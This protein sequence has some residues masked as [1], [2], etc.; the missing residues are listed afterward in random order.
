MH[1]SVRHLNRLRVQGQLHRPKGRPRHSGLSRPVCAGR[2]L[3]QVTPHLSCV[4]VH[5]LARWL[6]QQGHCPPVVAGLQPAITRSQQHRADDDFALFHH[7]DQTLRGRLQAL[8]FA[9]LLGIEPVAGVDTHEHP[10]ETLLGRGSHRSPLQQVL[11]QRERGGAAGALRPALLP[12]TAGQIPYVDGVMIASWSRRSMHKGHIT[13]LGRLMAGSQA[14]IAHNAKGQALFVTSQPPDVQGSR[15]LGDSGHKG[16][17]ATGVALCVI[18]RA[19]HAGAIACAFDEHGFGWLC[20][21]DEHESDGRQSFAATGVDRLAD[22]P[23]LARGQW[24][25]PRPDDPRPCVMVEPVAGKPLGSWGTPT[26]QAAV[27]PIAWPRVYR[28]R[29]AMPAHRVKGMMDHGALKTTY[30]RKTRV[31]PDRHQ[32]RARDELEQSLAAAHKRVDPKAPAVNAHQD[33]V[34]ASASKGPGKRLAQRRHALARGDKA[35]QEAQN[36]PTKLREHAAAL[37]PPRQRA[38]RDVR[39]QTMMTFRTLVLANALMAFMSVLVGPLDLQGRLDCLLTILCER[40]GARMETDCHVVYWV[41][42]VGLSASSQRLLTAM[43]DGLCA[44]DL[45]EQG[46]PMHVRLKGLPP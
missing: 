6:D 42:T 13:M 34:A 31:G 22:G 39:T 2:A 46:K 15:V 21:R 27:E 17:R 44:M 45:R 20:R 14:L 11:G 40:S 9:P 7:R 38:E 41:N 1:G 10:L 19:V 37:G 4:G 36:N 3:V 25:V 12:E 16:A 24:N 26:L 33:K 32:Q 30:G 23:T 29:H 18:D 43:V 5:L 28:E 35:L 8:C